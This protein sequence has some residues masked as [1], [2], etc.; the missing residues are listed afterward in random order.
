LRRGRL[1]AHSV[2]AAASLWEQAFPAVAAPPPPWYAPSPAA[3][4][5]R[6]VLPSLGGAACRRCPIFN[7]F[8]RHPLPATHPLTVSQHLLVLPPYVVV[9]T[10]RHPEEASHGEHG[11]SSP[12]GPLC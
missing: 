7:F 10:Q 1:L 8:P 5:V 3:R 9:P 4:S 2:V 12:G 6:I 11:F